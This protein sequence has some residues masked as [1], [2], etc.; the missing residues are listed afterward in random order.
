MKKVSVTQV[1]AEIGI[2]AAIGFVLDEIQ[3]AYSV[4]FINGGSI[5]IAMIA[6]LI[7]AYR[8][9]WLPAVLTGL[10]I[11]LFDLATKAYIYHPAQVL[12]DYVLPH[13]LVGLSGLFKALFDKTDDKQ[14][15]I[16][17]LIVGTIVGGIAKF[18]S[19]FLSGVI[20]FSDAAGFAWNLNYMNPVLYSFVYNIAYIGPSIILA[21]VLLI[22][23]FLKARRIV[24]T[25]GESYTYIEKVE[26]RRKLNQT[27]FCSSEIGAGTF[28]FIYFLIKYISSYSYKDKVDYIKIAFD[29][30]CMVIFILGFLLMCF[31]IYQ[32]FT[33]HAS[34]F[35]IRLSLLVDGV[36]ILVF[37]MYGLARILEMY[38]DQ[39]TEINNNYWAWFI[40]SLVIGV[41][42]IVIY[43]ILRKREIKKDAI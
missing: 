15:K 10:I 3:G 11:G 42:L 16:N 29:K 28:L 39:W 19:H 38:I 40:P 24:M 31:G 23:L 1:I 30:D 14:I 20:F 8:R 7:I 2:F 27:I 32:L 5:G 36:L 4:S 37:S 18:I 6:V 21:G 26:K 12:L 25:E 13:A 9:G 22:I 35:K 34:R 33:V 17:Y 41:I 43:F